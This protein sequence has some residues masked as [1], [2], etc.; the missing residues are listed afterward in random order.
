M[1][2]HLEHAHQPLRGI[3]RLQE[4]HR[5]LR[6]IARRQEKEEKHY[7]LVVKSVNRQK[8]SLCSSSIDRWNYRNAW[9]RLSTWFRNPLKF[10]LWIFSACFQPQKK[11]NQPLSVFVHR[12]FEVSAL[13]QS[14]LSR[15]ST[16][17]LTPLMF[18]QFNKATNIIAT[19]HDCRQICIA[20]TVATIV[21]ISV[22]NDP[23]T[24]KAKS[25]AELFLFGPR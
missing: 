23:A 22:Y 9:V 6:R 18:P 16:K 12:R 25:T 24:A 5:P 13:Q 20:S 4:A 19:P 14:H 17:L 2:L 3:G 8:K 15:T 21:V 10:M 11:P 1:V 7:E